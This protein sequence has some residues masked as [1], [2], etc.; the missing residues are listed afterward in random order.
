MTLSACA[1]SPESIALAYQ[2]EVPYLTWTCE[3]LA[4]E[5]VRLNLAPGV[6]LLL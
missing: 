2:T 4:Q 1:K 6:P 3:Q 5:D